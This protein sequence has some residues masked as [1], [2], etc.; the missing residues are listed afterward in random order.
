MK[1]FALVSG[2]SISIV[3]LAACGDDTVV[4]D[5]G[6]AGLDSTAGT[7]VTQDTTQ[8]DTTVNDAPGDT[9]VS[10]APSDALSDAPSDTGILDAL[11]DALAAHCTNKAQDIDETD[12]DCGG[13]VCPKCT[14]GQ[15]CL[16]STDCTSGICKGNKTCQ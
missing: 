16:V 14:A 11:P 10:D 15:K 9:T 6:E 4:P 5:A 12:I 3:L 1:I 7:D 13:L 2:V 8:Q